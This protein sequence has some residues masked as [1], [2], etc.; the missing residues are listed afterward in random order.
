MYKNL[1]WAG[2]E[3]LDHKVY[4]CSTSGN[5]IKSSSKTGC[6][7]SHSWNVE[8]VIVRFFSFLLVEWV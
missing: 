7:N 3:L 4:V 8:L 6:P 1:S 5:R 2:V